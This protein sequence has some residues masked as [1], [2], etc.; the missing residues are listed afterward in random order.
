MTFNDRIKRFKRVMA[1]NAMFTVTRM[2]RGIS[3]SGMRSLTR[4]LFA[5]GFPF[6]IKQKRLTRESLNIAF[7][8]EKSSQEV[9]RIFHDCFQN[10]ADGMMELMFC[11]EHPE[12]IP[13][14][15][16]F[17]GKEHLDNALKQGKG[18]IAVSAHFG[19]FPLMLLYMVRQGYKTNAIIRPTRDQEI[20]I[21]FQGLRSRLGLNTVYSLP[22]KQCVD[23]SIRALRNNE[24]LF[25]PLDQNFGSNGGVFVDFFG[26]KAA[27]AAGPIIF[28]MRTKSPVLPVFTVRQPDGRHKI[29]IE[30]PLEMEIK[31][32]DQETMVHNVSRITK[33]IETYI[34]RYPQE[35]GWMHRRWKSQ[36]TLEQS[37][38]SNAS[39]EPLL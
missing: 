1:R 34:R 16:Y 7:A 30:P 13:K 27:T 14:M 17:E 23:A 10:V 15:A 32:T 21:H 25:I 20:E 8:G 12:W 31:T 36:P 37:A 2:I 18:A 4:V 26:Q 38:A 9:D 24:V 6:L 33:I 39:T 35:W 5:I 22:R 28:A 11:M 29:I 19:N 3:Y